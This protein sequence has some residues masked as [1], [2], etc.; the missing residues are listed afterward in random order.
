LNVFSLLVL[1]I[2]A[3]LKTLISHKSLIHIGF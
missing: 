3:F 2:A 1:S